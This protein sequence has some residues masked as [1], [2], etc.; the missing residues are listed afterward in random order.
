MLQP[1]GSGAHDDHLHVRVFCSERDVLG[2][3][4][5]AGTEQRW[6]HGFEREKRER[7]AVV[8]TFLR[9]PEAEVRKRALDRLVLLDAPA[10]LDGVLRALDDPE[11]V[12]RHAAVRAVAAMGGESHVDRL[13][14]L[15]ATD[16]DTTVRIAVIQA[17][18]RLG[19][20]A[21]GVLLASAVG[22]SER[23]APLLV[24][25]SIALGAPVEQALAL[26]AWSFVR[27]WR[28]ARAGTELLAAEAL[29]RSVGPPLPIGQAI[30]TAAV[31]PLP[32]V[33]ALGTSAEPLG[34]SASWGLAT[35]LAEYLVAPLF[36]EARMHET[37]QLVAI[38]AAGLSER[39]EPVGPLIRLLDDR[40][41]DVRTAAD[42]ALRMLTNTS[43]PTHFD[44][45]LAT[46]AKSHAMWSA[47]WQ[48]SQRVP[49]DVWLVNG[50]RSA[51]YDV[52]EL[53]THRA[54]D[55][56]RATAGPPHIS[57]NA[58]RTLMRLFRHYP[59]SL[60]WSEHDACRHWLRWVA[61][62]RHQHRIAAPPATVWKACTAP[63][64]VHD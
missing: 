63:R 31:A 9:A 45:E 1:G 54:W 30:G 50:F 53:S 11:A 24:G 4:Q 43:Y 47:A 57:F 20:R 26:D 29:E 27:A 21:S 14:Q 62:H 22:T 58:Q 5:D 40:R 19:G 56:V 51:G 49:R 7:S 59:D 34:A 25:L 15:F 13:A 23:D 2:G 3:C 6:H 37:M 64:E 10:Q 36:A 17:A 38:D 16:A 48:R 12:V 52:R 46:R 42:R 39:F 32:S 44:G 28:A 55:L 33:Q 60:A 61:S 35:A 8:A 18:A 41:L